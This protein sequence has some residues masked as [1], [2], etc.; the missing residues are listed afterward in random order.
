MEL[1]HIF[2]FVSAILV[3][4]SYTQ[5]NKSTFFKQA[6]LHFISILFCYIWLF[7]RREKPVNNYADKNMTHADKNMEKTIDE[8]VLTKDKIVCL[9]SQCSKAA[10]LKECDKYARCKWT[11]DEL[12]GTCSMKV[13]QCEDIKTE[14]NCNDECLWDDVKHTCS[15]NHNM[16]QSPRKDIHDHKIINEKS[17]LNRYCFKDDKRY[18]LDDNANVYIEDLD[19]KQCLN[20][21]DSEDICVKKSK[22]KL[23]CNSTEGNVFNYRKNTCTSMKI[24]QPCVPPHEHSIG[25][26]PFRDIPGSRPAITFQLHDDKLLRGLFNTLLLFTVLVANAGVIRMFK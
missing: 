21:G 15:W 3:I 8:R 7:P 4:F 6:I 11:G 12:N 23:A 22:M 13:K 18:D 17:R 26:I 5:S 1:K 10:T 14:R 24:E 9:R 20:N 2:V 16:F 19:H 25:E